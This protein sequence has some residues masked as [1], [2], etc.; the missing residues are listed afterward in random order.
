MKRFLSIVLRE[1][2][3]FF[4]RAGYTFIPASE[5]ISFE[6]EIDDSVK[7]KVVEKFKT[8]TPFEYEEEYLILHLEKE[9]SNE[10]DFIQF[11]IQ[12]II[13]IYPLS[14][15]AKISIESK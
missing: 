5:L 3:T 2:F 6:G 11:D 13:A 4:Y 8:V 15:Q 7:E 1:Q 10:G 14:Q 12:S 9:T